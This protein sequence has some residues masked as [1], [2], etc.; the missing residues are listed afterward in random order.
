MTAMW[1]PVLICTHATLCA[2][3]RNEGP[4]QPTYEACQQAVSRA[5]DNYAATA[6]S[7]G[8]GELGSY[9]FTRRWVRK[10]CTWRD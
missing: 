7:L 2:G 1:I 4:P 9:E 10:E 6:R 5:L 8:L 3:T